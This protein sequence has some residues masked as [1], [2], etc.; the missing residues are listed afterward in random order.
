MWRGAGSCRVELASRSWK[1]VET[2]HAL[3]SRSARATLPS[4]SA[5]ILALRSAVNHACAFWARAGP[6]TTRSKAARRKQALDSCRTDR[7]PEVPPRATVHLWRAPGKRGCPVSRCVRLAP[8]V[9]LAPVALGRNGAGRIGGGDGG[10]SQES[11]VPTGGTTGG[12]RAL[13]GPRGSAP[14][15]GAPS[16]RQREHRTLLDGLHAAL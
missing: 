12:R 5:R 8:L 14:S 2:C 10:V 11:T 1:A 6:S 7:S 13:S 9:A 16:A 4:P 15:R 3:T